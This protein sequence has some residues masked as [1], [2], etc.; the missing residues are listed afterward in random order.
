[1]GLM[2]TAVIIIESVLLITVVIILIKSRR[3]AIKHTNDRIYRKQ[4]RDKITLDSMTRYDDN[5]NF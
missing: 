2:K 4:Y 1:M 3:D 5:V